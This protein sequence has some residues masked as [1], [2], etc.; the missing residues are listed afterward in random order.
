M[1]CLKV[2][3]F[4]RL[5][6]VMLLS[7]LQLPQPV[8]LPEAVTLRRCQVLLRPTWN[9]SSTRPWN[10]Y[11][12]LQ[13]THLFVT[14]SKRLPSDL[15]RHNGS[16]DAWTWSLLSDLNTISF[17]RLWRCSRPALLRQDKPCN[18]LASTTALLLLLLLLLFFV[19]MLCGLNRE[20]FRKC[21][22]CVNLVSY[23]FSPLGSWAIWPSLQESAAKSTN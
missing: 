3:V 17:N 16:L 8:M 23:E 14:P 7:P 12:D 15:R 1:C 2:L 6:Y 20:M 22:H 9:I 19:I 5:Q 13:T 18:H 4:V 11:E 21:D 10:K